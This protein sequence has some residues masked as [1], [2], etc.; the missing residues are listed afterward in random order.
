MNSTTSLAVN[1][2]TT[3]VST[4]VELNGA[5]MSWVLV[6]RFKSIFRRLNQKRL[7]LIYFKNRYQHA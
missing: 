7:N 1:D 3:T 2:T 5:D 6:I 4:P